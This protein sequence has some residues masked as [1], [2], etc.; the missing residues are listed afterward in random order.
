MNYFRNSVGTDGTF[1]ITDWLF[2]F[3]GGGGLISNYR[4]RITLPEELISITET[5]LWEF[6]QKISHYRYRFSLEFHAI[7]ITDTDFGLKTNLFC[8]HFGTLVGRFARID[9]RCEKKVSFLFVRIDLPE[10]GQQPG[11]D[12]NHANFNANRREDVIRA[13]LAKC[14]KTSFFFFVWIDSRESAKRWCANRLPTLV[15]ENPNLLK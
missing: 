15:L 3:G 9:S 2:F 10:N 7:S 11:K 12:A 1:A 6:Q 14:F 8:D 13:N 5:D 4:Y